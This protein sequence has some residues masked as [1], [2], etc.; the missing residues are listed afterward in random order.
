MSWTSMN[1]ENKTLNATQ[2]IST[3]QLVSKYAF[4]LD[5]EGHG[6]SG[7]LKYLLW[8]RRPL[9]LIDRPHK[10]IFFKHLIEW[11]HYIPVK[12]DLEDLVEKVK[13]CIDNYEKAKDIGENA[14]EFAKEYLTRERCYM[15]WDELIQEHIRRCGTVIQ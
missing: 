14:Y 9:L 10:E 6:Y 7:R 1:Q 11:V 4:M 3:Q 13:W 12:R 2:Y 15:D 8:S 5:I